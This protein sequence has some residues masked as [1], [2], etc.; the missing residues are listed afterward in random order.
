MKL[1]LVFLLFCTFIYN[2][3]NAY[4]S[5]EDKI[6]KHCG[7][8]I[9][10][11]H[12]DYCTKEKIYSEG[13]F[14]LYQRWH[15]DDCKEYKDN[16]FYLK[17]EFSCDVHTFF[18]LYQ[19]LIK[20]SNKSWSKDKISFSDNILNNAKTKT[21]CFSTILL[22]NGLVDIYYQEDCAS[23]SWKEL[24]SQ[25]E[26][27]SMSGIYTVE[28]CNQMYETTHRKIEFINKKEKEKYIKSMK[29]CSSI[30]EEVLRKEGRIE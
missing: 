6:C 21:Y 18:C 9:I 30:I 7:C 1:F 13:Q 10:T 17:C 24:S 29:E 27:D 16:E 20:F 2:N 25:K 3:A 8:G 5:K 26:F 4:L 14:L 28:N 12:K 11:L 15:N 23:E 19:E 22:Y